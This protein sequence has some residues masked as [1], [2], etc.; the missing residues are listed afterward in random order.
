MSFR[1][2]VFAIFFLIIIL[3]LNEFISSYNNASGQGLM[4]AVILLSAVTLFLNLIARYGYKGTIEHRI[5]TVFLL[6]Y[7]TFGLLSGVLLGTDYTNGL[8]SILPGVLIYF[9]SQLF[10]VTLNED[11]FD[12]FI[13]YFFQIIFCIGSGAVLI[14]YFL[15]VDLIASESTYIERA[16]GLYTNPN[17]A[18]NIAVIGQIF[19]L[20]TI[21]KKK[22]GSNYFLII[23]FLF[24]FLAALLTF[25]KTAFLTSFLTVGL[26]LY[27]SRKEVF[28]NFKALLTFIV[29]FVGLFMVGNEFFTSTENLSRHQTKIL[30]EFS[31]ILSGEFNVETTTGRSE[32]ASEGMEK[33]LERPF[34][35]FGLGTF[36]TS[37]S[38]QKQPIHNMYLGILGEAG[39]FPLFLYVGYLFYVIF[40]RKSNNRFN[41]F[42]IITVFFIFISFSSH[43]IFIFKPFMFFLGLINARAG[44]G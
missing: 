25:S 2:I 1:Y 31:Q 4:S 40:G 37:K 11:K 23:L 13:F 9:L 16:T 30:L 38:I 18:G 3:D 41:L 22:I 34:S 21:L 44:R 15:E 6:C 19:T 24:H 7:L 28:S 20:F 8:R 32:L 43:E 14:S 33:I 10:F 29:L 26:F 42:K 35:G 36:T 27:F 39:I 17:R 5:F 12:F